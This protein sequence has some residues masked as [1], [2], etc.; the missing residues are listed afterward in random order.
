MLYQVEEPEAAKTGCCRGVCGQAELSSPVDI[1]N[2]DMMM[3]VD[4]GFQKHWAQANE[5]KVWLSDESKV[6]HTEKEVDET[7]KVQEM[8]IANEPCKSFSD[9]LCDENCQSSQENVLPVAESAKLSSEMMSK[10]LM[11]PTS[12]AM[13]EDIQES[14]LFD[15]LRY[16]SQNTADWLA[17]GVQPVV[18]SLPHD[19]FPVFHSMPSTCSMWLL[20][21]SSYAV[22]TTDVVDAISYSCPFLEHMSTITASSDSNWLAQPC[23][24]TSYTPDEAFNF[25]QFTGETSKWYKP[26]CIPVYSDTPEPA[27]WISVDTTHPTGSE[28]EQWLLKPSASITSHQTNSATPTTCAFGVN[29]MKKYSVEQDAQ[30]WLKP[31]VAKPFQSTDSLLFKFPEF[32]DYNKWLAKEAKVE[33]APVFN[34]PTTKMEWLMADTTNLN[35]IQQAP[36]LVSKEIMWLKQ[37]ELEPMDDLE[38]DSVWLLRKESATSSTVYADMDMEKYQAMFP[39]FIKKESNVNEWLLASGD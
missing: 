39:A 25:D 29:F 34:I 35:H 4:A 27:T 10:W 8:C 23:S 2:L 38:E 30:E 6:D 13:M 14:P 21:S 28:V 1:E 37:E 7:E 19:L 32:T 11:K 12:V 5:G 16:M 20:D 36:A 26:R 3:C 33:K 9:C 17:V 22:P 31:D 24:Q 18:D 15:Y